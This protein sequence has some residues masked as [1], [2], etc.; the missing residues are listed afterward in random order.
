[1][2]S[3]T[4]TVMDVVT[5]TQYAVRD[6]D[7]VMYENIKSKGYIRIVT[8]LGDLNFELHCDMV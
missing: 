5:K 1:M 3:F 4:S 7:E 8:S 6:N 2:A